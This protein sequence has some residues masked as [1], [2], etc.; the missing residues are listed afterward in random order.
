MGAVGLEIEEGWVTGGNLNIRDTH[1]VKSAGLSVPRDISIIGFD[2][3]RYAGILDPPLTT[4]RQPA[5][6]IGERVMYRLFREI[7][8]SGDVEPGPEIVPHELVIRESVAP[9]R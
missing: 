7:E 4:V 9:P 8:E 5:R 6:L 2:D 3:N 1:A